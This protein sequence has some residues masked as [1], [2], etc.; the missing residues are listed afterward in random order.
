MEKQILFISGSLGLGHVSRDLAIARELRKQRPDCKIHWLAAEPASSV[1]REEGENLVNEYDLYKNDNIKAEA[2]AKGSHLNLFKYAFSALRAWLHNARLVRK[3]TE[4]GQYD[5]VIGDETYE[6]I[7]ATVL[8]RMKLNTPFLMLYDFLGLDAMSRN[9]LEKMGVYFWNRIWSLDR[10]IFNRDKNLALFIGELEDI[11]DKR[12]SFLLPNR[13][14]YAKKYYEFVGYIISFNPKEL[15]DKT[16]LRK[17]LGY[18]DR[19]L[20]V[21]SI[22]GTAIGRHL[23]ELCGKA[24]IIAKQHIPNLHMILVC[25]PRLPAESLNVLQ[26][27]GLE[28]RQ[29]VPDL[30][31][32]FAASDLA[33]VQGGGTTT[34]ELTALKRPFIYFPIEGHSEQEIVITE[35]LKRYQAGVRMSFADSTDKSLADAI[36]AHLDRRVKYK[37]MPINGAHN[38][39]RFVNKLI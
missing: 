4:Q 3:I 28:V 12:F 19:P 7:V 27:R 29:Y 1:L 34:L 36:I 14:E 23:L 9:P 8:K 15:D 13:K 30:H 31:E 39:V 25:G 20:I 11:P 38:I 18:E 33:I 6:I 26:D 32:H 24:Y 17:K 5:L 10:K 2:A 16:S 37:D 21:C 22:G 35:R